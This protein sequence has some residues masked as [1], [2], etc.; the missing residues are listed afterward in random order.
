ME[1][2]SNESIQKLALD[3]TS[4][5]DVE[6]VIQTILDTEGKLDI[7]VNNAGVS[8]ISVPANFAAAVYFTDV[9]LS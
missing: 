5:E 7:L 3:V 4:D 2:F 1:G 9:R 6:R 8:G